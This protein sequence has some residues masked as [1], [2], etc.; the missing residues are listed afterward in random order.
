MDNEESQEKKV[1]EWRVH[2]GRIERVCLPR[3][4]SSRNTEQV[5]KFNLF[6]FSQTD[7]FLP[8]IFFINKRVY[9]IKI[10]KS[11]RT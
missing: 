4:K 7:V 2:K 8:N 11:Q 1:G 9:F 3:V 6:H 10:S 5:Q